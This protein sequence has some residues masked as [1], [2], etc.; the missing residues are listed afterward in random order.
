VSKKGYIHVKCTYSKRQCF[1]RLSFKIGRGVPVL[2]GRGANDFY[3]L[4]S[5]VLD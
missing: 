2:I 1:K 3:C 5:K 4:V